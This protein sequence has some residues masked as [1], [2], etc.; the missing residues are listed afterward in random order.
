MCA[1]QSLFKHRYN[2]G[3]VILYVLHSLVLPPPTVPY[4]TLPRLMNLTLN[5]HSILFTN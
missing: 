4:L 5:D 2:A 3:W 1:I